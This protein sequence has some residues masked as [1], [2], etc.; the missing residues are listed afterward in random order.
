MH[1]STTW[2]PRSA[3]SETAGETAPPLAVGLNGTVINTDTLH[4]NIISIF[5]R[6]PI[7]GLRLLATVLKGKA[8]F[9]R[10]VSRI[11]PLDPVLLPYND[12]LIA[13]LDEQKRNGRRIGLFTAAHQSTAQAVADHLGVFD[14]VCGS[15]GETN[16]AGS[17]KL[18]AIR[19]AFGSAFSYA[20]GAEADRPVFCA[21]RSVVLAGDVGRLRRLVPREVAVENAF[22]SRRWRPRVWAKAL[23]LEHWAKN[24][25]VFLAPILGLEIT[26]PMVLMQSLL[27]FVLMGLLASATYLVNDATDLA[28][29]RQH[30]Y[31][32]RRPMAAGLI[33]VSDGLAVAAGLIAV[34]LALSLM[35]PLACT[36]ALLLYL[37]TTLAYSFA[38]KR[39][40]VVDVF[41][42]AGL[43]TLRV[44]AGGGVI[45]G[46]ISPWLLTFSMLFFLG[47]ATVKRYAEL[48]RVVRTGGEA[49]VSRGYNSRDLPLLLAAGIGSGLSAIVIFTMYLINDHYPQ[50]IYRHPEALWIMM[51]I[52]LLWTLRVWHMAV[53]GRMNEDPVTFALRDRTSLILGLFVIL[54]LA[55]AWM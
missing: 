44:I 16:L 30:P 14:V 37:A 51:P 15:D 3:D 8:H 52:L 50:T 39:Q 12:E 9:K 36:L 13:Y 32:R 54:A 43:F 28:A 25:L 24:V 6:D 27:L 23:R 31:K 46:P 22:P 49:V 55:V 29:D 35:L 18:E 21:S 33:A 1:S 41:V 10:E 40:P 5:R 45:A 11:W 7:Q 47:L 17:R 34:S 38:L 2:Q 53:H 42:L 26:S 20:G 19:E 48:E 4:E